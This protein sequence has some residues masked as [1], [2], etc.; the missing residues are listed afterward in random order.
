MPPPMLW[1]AD[2]HR[3]FVHV[4][5]QF[6]GEQRATHDKNF[7]LMNRKELT[8]DQV[9]THLQSYRIT[10]QK[11]AIQAEE[12]RQKMIRQMNE[13][14][15]KQ[16]LRR[17]ERLLKTAECIQNQQK[18]VQQEEMKGKRI[19]FGESSNKREEVS[20]KS[21]YQSSRIG[22]NESGNDEDQKDGNNGEILSLEL[23]LGLKY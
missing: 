17:Y 5:E 14:E 11:E 22:L 13:W 10:K 12:R 9:K 21:L 3:H 18:R 1:N 4:V 15:T 20:C 6:G 23:T 2:R 7:K 8:I 16:H 19:K